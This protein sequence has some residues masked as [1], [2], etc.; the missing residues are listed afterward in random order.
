MTALRYCPRCR[1][2]EPMMKA[3]TNPRAT[4]K[5]A[6]QWKCRVKRCSHITV[7]PLTTRKV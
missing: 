2:T 1:T 6:Q 4:G 3:G 5:R 7:N